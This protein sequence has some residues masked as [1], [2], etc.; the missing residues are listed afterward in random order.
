MRYYVVSD[1]HG[2]FTEFINALRG[3]GWFEDGG[4]KALIILGD[5]FDR[6]KEAKQLQDFVLELMRK[7]QVILIKGNHE[8]IMERLVDSAFA[9]DIEQAVYT[10]NGTADTAFQLTGMDYVRAT[11]MPEAFAKRLSNTPFVSRI[12]PEMLDYYE[13]ESFVF[14]HGW[15]PCTDY[16]VVNGQQR[17]VSLK[18]WRNA[19]QKQRS[20]SRW[21]NGIA[22]HYSG[23]RV[24]GKT[25]VCGHNPVTY[26][27]VY[28]RGE[29]EKYTPYYDDGII[30]IDGRVAVSGIVNCIVV[31]DRE[32]LSQE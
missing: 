14:V 29:E 31:E 21:H 20:D 7:K 22:A 24:A 1:L 2:Y 18:D 10:R 16:G 30:A 4:E 3:K 27:H 19:T 5:L 8:E 23:V 26:G 6:G 9:G 28:L 13:T 11:A 32:I 12:I 25:V 17:F 15:I